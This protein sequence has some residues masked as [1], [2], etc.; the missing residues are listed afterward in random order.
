[1]QKTP[2]TTPKPV[3]Q[4]IIWTTKK[5]YHPQGA[6]FMGLFLTCFISMRKVLILL[7]SG[8]LIM[9]IIR[10]AANGGVKNPLWP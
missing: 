1:M 5:G 2:K 8:L 3:T 7:V 9:P 4:W 10:N 6:V